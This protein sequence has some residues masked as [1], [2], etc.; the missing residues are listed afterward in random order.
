VGMVI[1]EV[2]QSQRA[3]MV[4]HELRA[5]VE[6]RRVVLVR[7]D[8]E[9]RSR[10]AARA[11]TEVRRHATDEKPGVAAGVL[12]DPRQE[13]CGRGLAVGGGGR[14]APPPFSYP[15]APPPPPPG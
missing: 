8:D 13:R 2:V 14:G 4:V 12:Q 15:R 6:E 7:L 1:L 3:R 5:F 9:V 11:H 10:A